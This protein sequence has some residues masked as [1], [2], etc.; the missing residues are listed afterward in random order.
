MYKLKAFHGHYS[1]GLLFSIY[2]T[3]DHASPDVPVVE[4]VASPFDEGVGVDEEILSI[5]T[6]QTD[7]MESENHLQPTEIIEM[8][9]AGHFHWTVSAERDSPSVV[10]ESRVFE[11][12]D[13]VD[14]MYATPVPEA[15]N[16]T[17]LGEQAL[18]T[19]DAMESA[20]ATILSGTEDIH[21]EGVWMLNV[22]SFN[23]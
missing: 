10:E 23:V 19:T 12:P 6:A 15:P 21:P 1:T 5:H 2:D 13:N 14:D 9:T 7:D 17:K 18:D 16:Q 20:V 22:V 3:I 11:D 4:D 8:E